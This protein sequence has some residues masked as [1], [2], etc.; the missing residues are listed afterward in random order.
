MR[1]DAAPGR[2]VLALGQ[3]KK[4]T[5]GK[6]SS[7]GGKSLHHGFLKDHPALDSAGSAMVRGQRDSVRPT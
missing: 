1:V 5:C 4:A 2:A 7:E 6:K 3:D